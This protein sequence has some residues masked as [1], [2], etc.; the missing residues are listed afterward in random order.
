MP[1]ERTCRTCWH[2]GVIEPGQGLCGHPDTGGAVHGADD[3]CC[4]HLAIVVGRGGYWQ[5][6]EQLSGCSS[7][8]E[9]WREPMVQLS[10]SSNPP[11]AHVAKHLLTGGLKPEDVEPD[12]LPEPDGLIEWM[13]PLPEPPPD[14][15]ACAQAVAER[16][17]L[18]QRVAE[19]EAENERLRAALMPLET[20]SLACAVQEAAAA[21]MQRDQLQ[22]A[23]E[24]E[25][26][27]V[28]SLAEH[29]E[30][31]CD[32]FAHGS[33]SAMEVAP[34]GYTDAAEIAARARKQALEDAGDA[35]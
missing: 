34:G 32:G 26:R 16:D 29:I 8:A 23:L 9:D 7:P 33:M 14:P 31:A 5:P 18:K 15:L 27:A 13:P 21:T 4:N 11:E 22:A 6:H 1:D 10:S 19:L 25:R 17:L 12:G 35:R 28:E 3:T 30:T 2:W 20:S 24:L